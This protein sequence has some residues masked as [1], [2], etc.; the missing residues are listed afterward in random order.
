MSDSCVA[1]TG[2]GAFAS[3]DGNNIVV[4]R[5]DGSLY[6]TFRNGHR[7]GVGYLYDPYKNSMEDH[8]KSSMGFKYVAVN[9]NNII[10]SKDY[11]DLYLATFDM[12]DIKNVTQFDE[13]Y[14]Q[15]NP[16]INWERKINPLKMEDE[17]YVGIGFF[18][19]E[20]IH[21]IT[22]TK[23][24][25][26]VEYLY[27]LKTN[28][29]INLHEI[30]DTETFNFVGNPVLFFLDYS[31][32]DNN[33]TT[34]CPNSGKI[35][36]KTMSIKDITNIACSRQTRM[37]SKFSENANLL[38]ILPYEKLFVNDLEWEIHPIEFTDEKEFYITHNISENAYIVATNK[39]I[40]IK[41]IGTDDWIKAIFDSKD[42]YNIFV[43]DI[44]YDTTNII[45]S[46]ILI[47]EDK[48]VLVSLF[49][50]TYYL[51]Y[52]DNGAII[53]KTQLP[54]IYASD[55]IFNKIFALAKFNDKYTIT[56][57]EYKYLE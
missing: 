31:K 4:T 20:Y 8:R 24:N 39:N 10:L 43:G 52:T 47:H 54:A 37:L 12:F 25:T 57:N 48:V 19:D 38:H 35:E 9:K 41:L 56:Y 40:Y 36:K 13:T 7:F 5:I 29:W 3:Y 32:T 14:K 30:N 26:I 50:Y 51:K 55:E 16:K 6:I 23:S 28:V 17:R 27:N 49:G 44:L 53:I 1:F 15:G 11:D 42:T 45:W 21:T 46:K 2:N 18:N 34:F 33:L 22:Q